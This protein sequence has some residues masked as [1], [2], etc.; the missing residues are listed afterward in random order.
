MET[1]TKL[2]ELAESLISGQAQLQT[3]ILFI[4]ILRRLWD[5]V[6]F[7]GVP[8]AYLPS[9]ITSFLLSALYPLSA[10]VLESLWST[11]RSHISAW[12]GPTLQSEVDNLFR[13]HGATFLL[14]R[15]FVEYCGKI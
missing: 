3:I 10:D 5:H 2:T 9:D 7:E 12:S 1:T 4:Y 15:T 6:T 11:W 14:G 13:Q 8:P